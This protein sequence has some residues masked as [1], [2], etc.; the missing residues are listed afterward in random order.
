MSGLCLATSDAIIKKK[1]PYLYLVALAFI[2]VWTIKP[3]EKRWWIWLL[4]DRTTTTKKGEYS[5][6]FID[7]VASESSQVVQSK[8]KNSE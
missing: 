2:P 4:D 3:L 7:F 1:E 6:G 8:L 5:I